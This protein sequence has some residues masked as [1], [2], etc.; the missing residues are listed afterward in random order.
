MKL[1]S[2]RTSVNDKILSFGKI[3]KTSLS[4][5]IVTGFAL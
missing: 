4:F 1:I 2:R 3:T 5:G